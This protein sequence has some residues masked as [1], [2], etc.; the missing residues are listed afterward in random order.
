M[1]IVRVTKVRIDLG[2]DE[3][4][5]F[6]QAFTDGCNIASKTAFDSEEPLQAVELQGRCYRTIRTHTHLTA[7]IVSTIPRIVAARYETLRKLKRQVAKPLRFHN[8]PVALQGGKRGRDFRFLAESIS[9]STLRGRLKVTYHGAHR[10]ADYL[11]NRTLGGALLTVQR[12]KVYLLVSFKREVP[13]INRP[14]DAVVA[15]DRGI[16]F[17]AVATDG[18]KTLFLRGGH[19][20][21]VAAQYRKKR[22]SLQSRRAQ[23]NTR[24][25][26]RALKRLRGKEARFNRNVNHVAS[27]R[28]VEFAEKCGCPT[29]AIEDLKGIGKGKRLG[30]KARTEVNAWAFHQFA[31]FLKYKAQDRGFVVIAVD[32]RYTS[33]GCSR[34]GHTE[35]ANRDGLRFKCRACGH[36]VHSDLNASRNIRLRGILARQVPCQDGLTSTS[37]QAR[38]ID[39]GVEPG[40][41]DGQAI[42]SGDGS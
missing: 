2:L 32:P 13:D 3:A 6:I 11:T 7:Q 12:G 4:L 15:V 21:T 35:K 27:K 10:L 26:R 31:E 38:P 29:I 33:Q 36:Q 5:R 17:T 39:P 16:R 41:G 30:K 22:A 28:V 9:L 23:K 20:R 1:E 42:A 40:R 34:C 25:I 37:P 24:S 19:Q 18:K 14:N 8:E